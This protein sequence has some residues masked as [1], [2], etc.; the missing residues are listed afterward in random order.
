[1]TI[2]S[3]ENYTFLWYGAAIIMNHTQ[4]REGRDR[5]FI[6]IYKKF[7]ILTPDFN[8][9]I[10]AANKCC[11]IEHSE[12]LYLAL[13]QASSSLIDKLGDHNIRES[14][15]IISKGKKDNKILANFI[16]AEPSTGELQNSYTFWEVWGNSKWMK[17]LENSAKDAGFKIIVKYS[18]HRSEDDSDKMEF[19]SWEEEALYERWAMENDYSNSISYVRD[20]EDGKIGIQ[21]IK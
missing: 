17:Y 1:M 9:A 4:I 3:S 15:D 7:S 11:N 20:D 16:S 19:G 18:T 14:I 21:L 5:P 10:S 12:H 13:C 2:M 6:Q 8:F